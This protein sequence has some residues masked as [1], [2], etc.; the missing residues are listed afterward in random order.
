[1][2]AAQVAYRQAVRDLRATDQTTTAAQYIA[3]FKRYALASA[4][5]RGV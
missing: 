1:V 5:L 2:A 3:I 4:A